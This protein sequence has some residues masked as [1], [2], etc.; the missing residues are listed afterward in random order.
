VFRLLQV[1]HRL[2]Q[3]TC[4]LPA[5]IIALPFITLGLVSDRIKG[6][7]TQ[8][9]LLISRIPFYLGEKARWFYYRAMLL[10]VGL[11][12][13]FRYGSF[14]QYRKARI[15][16]RV[17][18][19]Y[20]NTIGEVNIADNVLIGGNVNLL[21]G[22]HHHSFDDPSKLIWD[23]PAKGRRMI[24]IG[25]D[26]WIGSNSVIGCDIGDRCVVSAGELSC[27]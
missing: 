16:N 4:Y 10:S 11:N 23:T 19:G 2:Y 26:V 1:I 3:R 14:F 12:V 5:L 15:G 7:I 13:T 21:S 8:P 25:S 27:I 6:E 18:I 20:F 22:L 24:T 17:L 9:S